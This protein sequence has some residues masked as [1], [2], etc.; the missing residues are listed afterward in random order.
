MQIVDADTHLQEL[1][2]DP[3]A[4][5]SEELLRRMDRSGVDKSVVWLQPPYDRDIGRE[6]RGI[7]EAVRRHP[8]RLLGFGWVN[9]RLGLE[10]A[11]QELK[12][13]L[14]DY[15]FYGIKFN[16][17][18]DDYQIDTPAV[19]ELVA[20]VVERKRVIA[21]H[22]GGD[23]PDNT[24]P[25]RFARIVRHFPEGNFLMVHMG[26]AAF[27]PLSQAAI[28]VAQKQPNVWLVGSA[29]TETA[30]IQAL[31]EVGPEKVC[32]GSDTPFF[33]MHV[34]VAKYRALLADFPKGYV[35]KVMGENILRAL[36]ITSRQ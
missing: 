32:F 25:F 19:L 13:C 28:E 26:G 30:I 27:P 22:V 7:F 4:I 24:H 15:G 14:E 9:P 6:N 16:G 35:P 1:R 21:F 17:A 31:K 11:R 5:D 36:G 3:K 34:Q 2:T 12:R 33:L 10:K 23:S 20:E 18:Q 29:V 8:D